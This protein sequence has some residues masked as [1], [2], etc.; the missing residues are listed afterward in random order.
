M[1]PFGKKGGVCKTPEDL[2]E[3]QR[4]R[5][6]GEA[7]RPVDRAI[8]EAKKQ[9]AEDERREAMRESLNKR[10][11]EVD[12]RT[13]RLQAKIDWEYEKRMQNMANTTPQWSPPKPPK[14]L[15][16]GL[17]GAIFGPPGQYTQ[18]NTS[19]ATGGGHYAT[20][21]NFSEEVADMV[22]KTFITVKQLELERDELKGQIEAL[23]AQVEGLTAMVAQTLTMV[24]EAKQAGRIVG[25]PQAGTLEAERAKIASCVRQRAVNIGADVLREFNHTSERLLYTS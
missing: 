20:S 1:W 2:M 25:A 19:I 21:V 22:N 5:I 23:K 13:R 4:K 18:P 11:A 6:I 24:V 12:A 8:E 16:G 17:Q 9:A 10:A 7:M 14:D 15:L 3:E